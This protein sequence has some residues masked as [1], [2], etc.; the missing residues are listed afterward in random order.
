VKART[1]QDE[2]TTMISFALQPLAGGLVRTT[3][4][5]RKV[6]TNRCQRETWRP[7]RWTSREGARTLQAFTGWK[8][9][10]DTKYSTHNIIDD[11]LEGAKECAQ[12]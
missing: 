3:I 1:T 8:L 5:W 9:I 2:R 4:P 10:S 7:Q 6:D 12:I 11:Q